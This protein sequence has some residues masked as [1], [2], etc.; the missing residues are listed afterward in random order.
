MVLILLAA[1]L[2]TPPSPAAA[3]VLEHSGEIEG[4]VRDT[5]TGIPLAG[6][7]VSVVGTAKTA[8]THGDGSFHL[9]GIAEG[10]Y[11][12]RIQRPGYR[13]R[14]IEVAVAGDGEFIEVQ[15]E[16]SPIPLQGIVVTAGITERGAA[17]A[18]RPA[19][20]MAGDE[21]Q[22]RMNGTVAQTLASIPGLAET[23]MGP[24]TS[25]PVIRGLSGDRVLMLED[26]SRVG[27]VSSAGPDHA[28]AVDPASA[29]R[30]E[31]VR[32]PASLLYGSNALGGV[33]N[34]IRDEIPSAVP[35]HPT[36]AASLQVRTV[37]GSVAGSA[38]TTFAATD[39]LPLRVE[40]TGRTAG[41]LRTP[42]GTLANTNGETFNAA[43]GGSY[44]AEWGH[45][46]GSVRGYRNSYG[47]PGGFVGGHVGGVRVE[48]ERAASRLRMTIEEPF[49][50]FRSVEFDGAYTW[51]RHK[52]LE[53][54]NII[55]TLFRLQ[56]LSGDALARHRAWGPFSGGAIGARVA[57]EAFGFGGGGVPSQTP[58]TNRSTVAA[59]I[60]EEVEL[61]RA[62]ME[63]G[64]RYDW[65]FISPLRKDP[66]SDIG[67]IRDRSFH[68]ASASLGLL[69]NAGSGVILGASIA[70]A[71]RTPDVNELF[72]EGPHLAA[73]TFEVGNPSLK[74]EQGTGVDIFARFQ[75]SRFQ[76]ELTVFHNRISDY[77]YGEETGRLSRILLPIYQ[78]QSSDAL[79][80]GFEGGLD[81]D[82]GGG[83]V[84]QAVASSVRGTLIGSDRPIP[85]IPPLQ[86]R[87]GVEYERT[88]WFVG[89]D[90][91]VAAEQDRI[92][93]FEEATDGYAV[94]NA[95]AGVR[96]T[97]GGRLNVVTLSLDN[98]TDK[99]YRN[100]LSRVKEIMPEAGRGLSLSYRVVF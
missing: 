99:E 62:R 27:D 14:T 38:T 59:Y 42:A 83:L 6:A 85:L 54:A 32:G 19:S 90:A 48:M 47:I 33:I 69:Y 51:Y 11:T 12:L 28:T 94:L 30:I 89:L 25:S 95:N 29:R 100:H 98:I 34:V 1:G 57:W 49:A 35:H 93:A 92:G 66:V 22:R 52:E 24:A 15:L 97:V 9:T 72:S 91:E 74:T 13:G 39:R 41:D 43:A 67:D 37:S 86:G 8:I 18:L 44:V 58:D 3:Q 75:S 63:A 73:Y 55:G 10:S 76:A 40:V 26:G 70:R 5:A 87:A 7:L 53:S 17:E 96:L 31:V 2:A 77:I 45:A 88:A 4:V 82:V 79:L 23:S 36:G 80:V 16:T 64:L 56:T 78:F 61:G 84:L 71:F 21:L 68:A 60:F 81:W 65:V 50:A 20:V 46:G